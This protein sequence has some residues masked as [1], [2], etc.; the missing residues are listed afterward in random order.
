MGDHKRILRVVFFFFV[1]SPLLMSFA[2]GQ[3]Q[4]DCRR[5]TTK[6]YPA[7]MCLASSCLSICTFHQRRF[8]LGCILACTISEANQVLVARHYY[9]CSTP[10][11]RLHD[12]LRSA[13][14]DNQLITEMGGCGAN[15][16]S[17]LGAH[18][19]GQTLGNFRKS[20][21]ETSIANFISFIVAYALIR[22]GSTPRA[23]PNGG[24]FKI[25][26]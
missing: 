26:G 12:W 18:A 22:H 13:W 21:V 15:R 14:W 11:D 4:P 10:E 19:N 23:A 6:S 9:Q 25:C 1:S 24:C 20:Q 5:G 3:H 2:R 7:R 16:C 17:G 8:Y